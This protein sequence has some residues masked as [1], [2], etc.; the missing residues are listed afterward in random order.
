MRESNWTRQ[1]GLGR[2]GLLARWAGAP[3]RCETAVHSP[4][5]PGNDGDVPEQPPG[6]GSTSRMNK[7]RSAAP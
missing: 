3:G 4:L 1:P 2:R 5:G 7:L 6:M